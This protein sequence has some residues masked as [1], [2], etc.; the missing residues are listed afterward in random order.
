MMKGNHMKNLEIYIDHIREDYRQWMTRCGKADER[1][2]D[3]VRQEMIEEFVS[4]VRAQEGKK[5]VK[6]TTSNGSGSS[7]HSFIVKKTE[8]KFVEGDIL[9]AASWSAPAKNF[10]RGNILEKTFGRVSWTGAV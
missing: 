7:A 3:S 10:A 4:N 5:F 1:G 6:V 9:M 2:L 8:G